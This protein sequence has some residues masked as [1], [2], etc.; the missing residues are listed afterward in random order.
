MMRKLNLLLLAA[1]IVC[2]HVASVTFANETWTT[3]IKSAIASGKQSG[4]DVLLLYTGSDWCPPCKKLEQEIFETDAFRDEAKNMFELVMFDFPKT[5]Q[6]P[7]PI[8]AQNKDWAEK[9]GISAYPTIVL[10]DQKQR[11]FAITGYRE[12]DPEEYLGMLGE[13]RQKRIRRDEAFDKA[14][15][16]DDK[17]EKAKL[18]DQAMSEMEEDIARL[19]Y[20]EYI[21]EIVKI[22]AEDELGLRTKWNAAKDSEMRKLVITEITMVS[23]L[24]KPELSIKFIDEVLQQFKFPA[25]ERLQIMQIKLNLLRKLKATAEMDKLL[26]EMISIEELTDETRERLMVKKVLLMVGTDRRDSAMILIDRQIA[27]GANSGYLWLAKGQLQD[28]DRKHKAAIE[29]FDQAMLLRNVKPDLLI[30][31]IGAK[32]DAQMS[33]NDQAAAIKT[34]DDFATNEEMPTDLRGEAQLQMAMI[35]REA[36][37]NRRAIVA[38]NR[39]VEIAES[40]ESRAEMQKLVDRLRRRFEK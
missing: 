15:I 10:I 26:D 36:G 19:Y 22:D 37:R 34:L 28:S 32:A 24:Q 2:T 1:T 21:S 31:L 23:R 25:A 35:M 29:S 38:E 6:L 3:D 27:D 12:M 39:A 14:L 20:E 4:K 17:K 8:V 40:P 11:P 33:L 9:Y 16:T 13:F 7:A 18:L 30:E 5:K